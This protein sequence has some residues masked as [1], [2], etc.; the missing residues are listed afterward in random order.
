MNTRYTAL[1][2]VSAIL[3]I[4]G[5]VVI[6][7][8]IIGTGYHVLV[9]YPGVK[10][11]DGH[12]AMPFAALIAGASHGLILLAASEGIHVLLDIEENTRRAA[13]SASGTV[14]ATTPLQ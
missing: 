4:I 11:W 14:A 2:I 5:W 3:K 9:G 12:I 10:F 1:P 13:D 6:I 7:L 8:A